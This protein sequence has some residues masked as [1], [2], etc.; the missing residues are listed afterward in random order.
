[1]MLDHMVSKLIYHCECVVYT[2]TS[3]CAMV[4]VV[5]DYVCV[6]VKLHVHVH[7][8]TVEPL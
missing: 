7:V 1:M 8:Y 3:V 6:H 4:P 2:C 5:Y